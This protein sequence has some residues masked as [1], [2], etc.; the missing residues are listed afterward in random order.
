MRNVK[1]A[2]GQ[3]ILGIVSGDP[4][5]YLPPVGFV[6]ET[7]MAYGVSQF[8][9]YDPMSPITYFRSWASVSGIPTA[10][11]NNVFAPSIMTIFEAR[12]Y[13]IHDVLTLPDVSLGN[14]F[15][16]IQQGA[17]YK[18][19]AVPRSRQFSFVGTSP[20]ARVLS[21]RWI[22]N[23]TVSLHVRTFTPS[24]LIVRLTN[25]PGWHARID[26]HPAALRPWHGIMQALTVPAGRHVISL[27][28]WPRLF[29][30]GLSLCAG[31]LVGLL[32][33]VLTWI[34]PTRRPVKTR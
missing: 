33:L 5:T 3:N 24:R 20:R 1:R 4:V 6:T 12:T 15:R 9:A 28:Y 31:G 23:Y 27:T 29:T 26:G 2:V 11:P 19:Y 8:V 7:N 21:Q 18:L 17:N 13:G 22:N 30:V 10:P 34:R 14:G 16:L 32:F 25:I